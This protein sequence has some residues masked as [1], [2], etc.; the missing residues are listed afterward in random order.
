S[1]E[2]TGQKT[3]ARWKVESQQAFGVINISRLQ[4]PYLEDTA[5][6]AGLHEN[7][8][9]FLFV[10]FILRLINTVELDRHYVMRPMAVVYDIKHETESNIQKANQQAEETLAKNR[11]KNKGRRG[12]T[13]KRPL[14]K[15]SVY[16]KAIKDLQ[17]II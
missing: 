9:Y 16:A 17:K 12:F 11:K 1:A 2:G 3:G 4:N 13:S 7:D 10:D 14:D 8:H 15:E 5:N 6:R